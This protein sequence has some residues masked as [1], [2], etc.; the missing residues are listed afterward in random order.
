MTANAGR[1]QGRVFIVA[2]L[3]ACVQAVLPPVG[4]LF[5]SGTVHVA[6][7]LVFVA[8]IVPWRDPRSAVASVAAYVTVLGIASALPLKYM[9]REVDLGAVDVALSD[10]P[11]LLQANNLRVHPSPE[12]LP[13][14]R[15]A[16]PTSTPSL[17]TLRSILQQELG[18]DL[19]RMPGCANA[20]SIS[21]LWGVRS[22]GIRLL[23]T[24]ADRV[25]WDRLQDELD[26]GPPNRPMQQAGLAGG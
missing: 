5:V 25:A 14:V 23:L 12:V 8:A 3:Y 19:K 6:F 16:L 10:I 13:A 11:R 15:V 17:R 9:D 21:F 24:P 18:V 4:E 22:A 1:L 20:A 7:L 2:A 26:T